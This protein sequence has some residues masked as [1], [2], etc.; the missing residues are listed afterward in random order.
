MFNLSIRHLL[1]EGATIALAGA[2]EAQTATPAGTQISNTASVAYTVNGTPQTTSSTTATF[3]VDRKVN[4]AVAPDQSG[5]T[6]VNLA[7]TGAVV[8]FKVTNTTNAAQ[9]F[10]LDPDQSTL[11]VGILTGS[12]NFDM[13]GLHAFVDANGNG[14]YDPTVDTQTYIDELAPDASVTVSSSRSPGKFCGESSQSPRLIC[15]GGS[16]KASSRQS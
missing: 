5:N 10:L 16:H 2:A 3:V 13:S 4:F 11:S 7:D 12:D 9:D 1:M 15:A 8:K 14:V 6:Q